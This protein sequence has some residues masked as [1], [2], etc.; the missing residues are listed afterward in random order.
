VI[1]VYFY[2]SIFQ[3]KCLHLLE[4]VDAHARGLVPIGLRGGGCLLQDVEVD[5]GRLPG[6]PV[7]VM[8]VLDLS[9]VGAVNCAAGRTFIRRDSPEFVSNCQGSEHT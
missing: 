9:R 8:A 2:E 6:C 1:Y 5:V 4:G 3:D 7:T